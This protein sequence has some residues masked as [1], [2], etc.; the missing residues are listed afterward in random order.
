MNTELVA[1]IRAR[2]VNARQGSGGSL[3]GSA[4]GTMPGI[5]TPWYGVFPNGKTV[6][7]IIH[8]M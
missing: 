5:Y 8:I 1:K 4:R 2:T 7:F 3:E 6:E